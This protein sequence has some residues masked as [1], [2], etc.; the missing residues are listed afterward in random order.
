MRLKRFHVPALHPRKVKNISR[1]FFIYCHVSLPLHYLETFLLTL[2]FSLQQNLPHPPTKSTLLRYHCCGRRP[3][4]YSSPH[5]RGSPSQISPRGLG[6][7]FYKPILWVYWILYDYVWILYTN[8]YVNPNWNSRFN[9]N[10]NK[11]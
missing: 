1:I 4:F 11:S 10:W 8:F 6:M 7:K 2:S 3:S 5:R 9:P